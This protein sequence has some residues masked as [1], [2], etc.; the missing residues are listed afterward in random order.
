LK[1]YKICLNG[2]NCASCE[3]IVNRVAAANNAEVKDIDELNGIVTVVCEE[4]QIEKLKNDLA[5]KG[6]PE[7]KGPLTA[8]G[9]PARI[10]DYLFSVISGSEETH[11]ESKLLNYS[12]ATFALVIFLGTIAFSSAV[13]PV[14]NIQ[15]YIPFIFLAIIFSIAAIFSYNHMKAYKSLMSCST[16]MMV[17]MTVGMILGFMGGAIIG[18]TNGMFVGSIIGM[19][20]GIGAGVSLGRHCGSMGAMEGIMAGFMGGIMGAMTSLMLFTDNVVGFLYF[21]FA[22]SL[23]ILMGLSYMMHREAGTPPK[24]SL[25]IDMP[26]FIGMAFVLIF[27]LVLIMFFGPKSAITYL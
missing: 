11:I 3:K 18:A 24:D 22:I 16:G 2:L 12:L 5:S 6:F 14:A 19:A 20:L 4:T 17:G 27:V 26:M 15:E 7:R 23:A 9:D 13:L 21:V 1:E 25:K 10:V 8:R